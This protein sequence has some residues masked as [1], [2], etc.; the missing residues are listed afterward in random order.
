MQ[1]FKVKK[2][3]GILLLRLGAVG[4]VIRTLPCL[5]ALRKTY[6]EARL[7]W[8]VEAASATLLPGKPWLDEVIIFPR[9]AL[10]PSAFARNSVRSFRELGTFFSRLRNF[11]PD[12]SLDFQGSAKSSLIAWSSCAPLRIGYS[13]GASREGSFILN[14]SHVKPSSPRI[15]RIW[16]NLELLQPLGISKGSPEFHFPSIRTSEG[17]ANFLLSLG[18]AHP[19][20][21]HP[22]TSQRQ[23]HKRWPEARFAQLIRGLA[24]EGFLPILTWGP[25][26]AGIVQA[27]LSKTGGAGAA[28]P[29]MSLTE[30][31]QFLTHC[32][33]F[34]GGDTGPMHLAWTHGI[35]VVALFGSTDPSINGPLGNHHRILAPAWKPGRGHPK[36]GDSTPMNEI[37]PAEVMQAA[38]EL[39]QPTSIF[40]PQAPRC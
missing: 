24:A 30:M 26:E 33:L 12:I 13:P 7:A 20:A 39:L 15:N 8:V 21:V 38:M 36:R 1:P 31:R 32:R 40:N 16:K 4:D 11:R 18:S 25:G 29:P 14:N 27:I 34:I 28:A 19:I 35:P 22:G 17:I 5:T 9:K 6:P 10:G 23:S 37:S 2:G 3:D